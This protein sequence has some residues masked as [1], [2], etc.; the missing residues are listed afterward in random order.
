MYQTLISRNKIWLI[1]AAFALIIVTTGCRVKKIQT[2]M[3]TTWV[4]TWGT[5]PQL[6]EPHNMPPEPGL[7]YNTLRQ[8]VRVSIGGNILRLKLSNEFSASPVT[9]LSVQIAATTGEHTI[10]AVSNTVLTFNGNTAVTIP[11]GEAVVSDPVYF[12]LKPRMD[13]AVTIYYGETSPQIT[14]HPGS[15]TTSYIF[16][17]NNTNIINFSQP[18][19]TDR[20]YN[21]NRID[22][23]TTPQA[24]SIAILGNSIT[25]GRGS[26]TNEQNRWPD[27]L[28]ERLLQ[29]PATSHIGVL[30]MGI[31]GNAVLEGGLGPTGLSR[32][33]R[34]ILNQPGVKWA[35]IY[36]GVND[37]G[38]VNS[39]EMAQSK[40]A[41]LIDAYK[42]M[43][44]EAHIRGIKI[45]GATIMPFKGNG[46][47]NEYS[48]KCR[49]MVND[50]IRNSGNFDAVI[51]FDLV[52]Q[53]PEDNNRLISSFQN[54]G[55]HPDA[56]GYKKMGEWVDINLF[57]D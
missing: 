44:S 10:D 52:L 29:N 22:V 50:W 21:I 33:E 39:P 32:F 43:I 16:E 28:S 4:G 9:M 14:G 7:T 1:L 27:I 54:D 42:F 40:T 23:L 12:L 34:D 37:I 30:N 53:H 45:F 56:Q 20:W 17:G 36:H 26:I 35:I 18:I 11:A 46:Y 38:G 51:D 55:L 48:E 57:I 8:V 24:A 47:Y 15:R 49:Q 2:Q 19:P 25:D 6:V 31:G 5:A 3:P 13:V 41:A